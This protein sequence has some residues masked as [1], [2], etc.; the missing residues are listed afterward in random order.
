MRVSEL[1]IPNSFLLGGIRR[2]SGSL[3]NYCH[4]ELTTMRPDPM[5]RST[6]NETNPHETMP[7]D[8]TTHQ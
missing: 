3:S 8:E 1:I 2:E 7:L 4:D 5:I 6:T